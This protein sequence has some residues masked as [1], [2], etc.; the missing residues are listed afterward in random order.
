M[1]TI[2]RLTETELNSKSLTA[3]QRLADE[4]D[5]PRRASATVAD[6][7]SLIRTSPNF[8]IVAIPTPPTS[9][10]GGIVMGGAQ[11]GVG[12]TAEGMV[13]AWAGASGNN[14][15][16]AGQSIQQAIPVLQVALNVNP[17]Q[18]RIM[19]NGQEVTSSYVLRAG[20]RLEF[21]KPAGD[22]G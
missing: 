19:V 18:M 8:Q 14:F 17:A 9:P 10:M 2:I 11:V 12:V 22:K 3:L 1:A 6:L 13:Y 5:L 20:D 15:S 21:V 4:L 7:R 16:L